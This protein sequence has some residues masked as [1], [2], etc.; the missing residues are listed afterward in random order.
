MVACDGRVFQSLLQLLA[1]CCR[2]L[3]IGLPD[4]TVMTHVARSRSILMHHLTVPIRIK[5]L[6]C[7]MTCLL[8]VVWA[9][10]FVMMIR[11]IIDKDIL[12]PQKQEDRA[13]G[14]WEVHPE[15][16]QACDP[17]SC[18]SVAPMHEQDYAGGAANGVSDGTEPG[19]KREDVSDSSFLDGS[20]RYSP[21]GGLEHDGAGRQGW[22]NPDNGI[23]AVDRSVDQVTQGNAVGRLVPGRVL[24]EVADLV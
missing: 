22:S 18:D 24:P 4:S 11:A 1:N 19:G 14:G 17:G 7:V 8:I 12:W 16:S 6:G 20:K 13:E 15:E 23:T 2:F 10:V 9:A 21:A 5:I 3:S